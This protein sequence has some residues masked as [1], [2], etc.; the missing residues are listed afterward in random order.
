MQ[1]ED[2]QQ[3]WSR[4]LEKTLPWSLPR[5]GGPGHTWV[6]DLQPPKLRDNPF[7]S[8]GASQ[9]VVICR[10]SCKNSSTTRLGGDA[11]R[12]RE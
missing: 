9:F 12:T 7:L 2:G 4:K 8:F 1:A 3:S 10:S 6:L 11:R 5:E